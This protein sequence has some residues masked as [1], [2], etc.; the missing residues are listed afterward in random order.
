VLWES[1]KKSLANLQQVAKWNATAE[2][3]VC[4]NE[5]S[6]AA[7]GWVVRILG[8]RFGDIVDLVLAMGIC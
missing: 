7:G 6:Q 8:W 1:F 2:R 3:C 5:E 4:D